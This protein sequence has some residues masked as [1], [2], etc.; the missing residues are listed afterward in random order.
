MIYQYME[1]CNN[2]IW[3]NC[4]KE[5][6]EYCEK[7]AEHE[8]RILH[9]KPKKS[10]RI[11]ATSNSLYNKENDF[12][13]VVDRL[14]GDICHYIDKSNEHNMFI[15]NFKEGLNKNVYYAEGRM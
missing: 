15:W 4:T 3:T 9:L 6:F 5:W 8:V 1:R 11:F 10:L 7:S 13:G 14:E 12:I 2:D